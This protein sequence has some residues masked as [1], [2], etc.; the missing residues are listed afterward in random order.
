MSNELT[1]LKPME[2]PVSKSMLER[3]QLQ[4]QQLDIAIAI[5]EKLCASNLVPKSYQ[6]KPLDAAVA[7]QWGLDVGMQPMQ[8]LQNIAVINGIPTMWGDMLVAIVQSSPL[9][10]ELDVSYDASTATA[11][12]TT[13]RKGR[14]P[15]TYTYSFA[16][17]QA[18]GLVREGSAWHKHPQRMA[19][20]RARGWLLRNEYADLLKGFQVREVVIDDWGNPEEKD[21]TPPKHTTNS[22]TLNG[23]LESI[24]KGRVLEELQDK[25]LE[26]TTNEELKGVGELISLTKDQNLRDQLRVTYQDRLNQLKKVNTN[27]VNE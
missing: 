1:T 19:E 12:A 15:K 7:I 14:K 10:E 13:K 2:P 5:G 25:I 18:A 6:G 9:C 11:K 24:P 4:A 27:A 26:A 8:S 23:F 17:A 22:S 20:N 3:L 21:I 16:Q